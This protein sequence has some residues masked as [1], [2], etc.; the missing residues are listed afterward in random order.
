MPGTAFEWGNLAGLI[1]N[2]VEQD[3]AL[4]A[5]R[6]RERGIDGT[7]LRQDGRSRHVAALLDARRS[8]RFRRGR[9]RSAANEALSWN[10]AEYAAGGSGVVNHVGR[11]LR[12]LKHSD[13]LG[14]RARLHEF[15]RLDQTRNRLDDALD[16]YGRRGRGRRRRRRKQQG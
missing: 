5:R 4:K 14:D 13:F 6:P 3:A 15:P 1:D 16:D 9:K 7:S 11:K 10:A 2:R 8:R 12:F